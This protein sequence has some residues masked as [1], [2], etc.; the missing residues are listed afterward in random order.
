MVTLKS[1]ESCKLAAYKDSGGK[2]TIAYGDTTNVTPGMV[3]TQEEADERL[4]NHLTILCSE[5]SK[6][7]KV[8][9]SQNQSDALIIFTYNV[10]IGALRRS[11]LLACVNLCWF[12]DAADEFLKWD[13]IKGVPDLGLARR[14]ER[15]RELFLS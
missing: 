10:G 2:L 8:P 12:E 3:I 6:I 14:R 1:L 4:Q 13:E 5:M 7:I 15:E 9:L 11:H